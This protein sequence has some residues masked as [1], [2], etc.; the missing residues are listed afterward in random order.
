VSGT[1][2]L[3]GNP[4]YV[5]ELSTTATLDEI[6]QAAADLIKRIDQGEPGIDFYT[7]PLG[8]LPRDAGD[9][10]D[11]AKQLRNP[12]RRLVHEFWA[13]VPVDR[14]IDAPLCTVGGGDGGRGHSLESFDAM[15]ALGW[16]P[17]VEVDA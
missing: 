3:S 12:Q 8:A 7:T 2:N 1:E 9:V 11:A 17:K 4:F 13:R 14:E 5:L 6:E 16:A 10:R 15:T